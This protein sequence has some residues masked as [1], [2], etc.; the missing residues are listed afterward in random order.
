ML[1]QIMEGKMVNEKIMK[2]NPMNRTMKDN[3]LIRY[4][5]ENSESHEGELKKNNLFTSRDQ[6]NKK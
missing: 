1:F 4:K 2:S 6:V 5:T 3:T